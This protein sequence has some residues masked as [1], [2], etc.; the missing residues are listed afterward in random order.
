[1]EGISIINRNF[2]DKALIVA[3]VVSQKGI[4]LLENGAIWL[5]FFFSI[6]LV[7]NVLVTAALCLFLFFL[8]FLCVFLRL[9]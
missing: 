5:L 4:Y 7:I 2:T 8:L 3:N 9:R 6:S 1:M